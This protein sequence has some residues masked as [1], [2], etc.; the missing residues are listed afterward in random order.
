MLS[1][2]AAALDGTGPAI[3][4]LDPGLPEPALARIL[5]SFSP[6]ALHTATGTRSLNLPTASAAAAAGVRED[7]VRDDTAVVIATSGSTGAPKAVELSAAALTASAAASLRRIGAGPGER[8][9]CC[10][11]TFHIAGIGVL[12]RSLI[13]GLEPVIVPALNPEILQGSG[14]AHVSLVP[15]QLRRLLDAGASPGPVRTVLL[16][17]AASG[18]AL[19][20]EARNGGWRVVTTYG[21][22]ETC[23]GCVYDGIPLDD[24]AVRLGAEPAEPAESAELA[25]PAQS[26]AGAGLIQIRGPVLF[27]GYLGPADLTEA[28]LRD[29]WFQTADLGSWRS[30]GTLGVL[31][32]ADEVINTGGEKV[33]PGEVEAA[34]GT[35]EGVADVVVVGLPDADWGEA[36]TAFVVAADPA[37]P[38]ELEDLRSCVR[39]AVSVYAAPKRVVVVPEFPLLPSGKPDRMALRRIGAKGA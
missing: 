22:S 9:L 15:T 20:A 29:G 4:P 12:V 38:P 35:C 18:D 11:P 25:E 19:L 28:V 39:Q 21:M 16:G 1:A 6:A 14:C 13:S 17:G 37:A 3:L 33:V 36:V 10:L 8:W 5:G 31:G 27:S 7:G 32:R 30:D 34:L 23:G 24:V 2:L 26:G